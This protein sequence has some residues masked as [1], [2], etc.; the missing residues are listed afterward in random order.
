LAAA[1]DDKRR[2][3]AELAVDERGGRGQRLSGVLELVERLE[4]DD[5]RG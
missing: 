4:L 2:T 1:A 5:L 3:F